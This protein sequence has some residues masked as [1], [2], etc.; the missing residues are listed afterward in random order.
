MYQ[1]YK[2]KCKVKYVSARVKLRI[3]NICT[4]LYPQCLSKRNERI[5]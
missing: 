4:F 3:K 2:M 1:H 5:C